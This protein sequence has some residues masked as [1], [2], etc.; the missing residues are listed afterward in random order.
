MTTTNQRFPIDRYAILT[1]TAPGLAAKLDGWYNFYQP[2][3]PGECELMDIAV[4]ASVQRHRVL[5]CLTE[6]TNQQVRTAAFHF[7]CDEE[8]QVDHYRGMLE[9]HPGAAV[10]GLKRSA[11]GMRFLIGRWA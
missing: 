6:I 9:T 1:E 8:N 3:S 2:A 10:V 7:D 4:M 11:L 5:A